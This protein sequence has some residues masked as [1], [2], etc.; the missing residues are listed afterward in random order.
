MYSS[1]CI[2]TLAASG[3]QDTPADFQTAVS[4][5]TTPLQEWMPSVTY[6]PVDNEFLLL[7][8]ATGVRDPGGENMYSLHG[9]RISPDG[10]LLGEAFMPLPTIDTARRILPRAAHNAFTNQ[11]MVV[12]CM[13][14]PVTGWD[15]F[16]TIVNSTGA[17]LAGPLC[18]SAQPT[19]ANHAFI[20]FN[21]ARRQYLIAYNDSRSGNQ[22]VFGVIVDEKGAVVKADFPIC[23]APGEQQNP[24]VC[25]NPAN[26]TFLINWEDFRN[27]ATWTEPGDMYGALLDG[28]GT[29]IKADIDR[30]SVV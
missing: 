4:I 7:W 1:S 22:D 18:L 9:R 2:S 15:P 26:D 6:N 21:P 30:K 19:N 20:V 25:Y 24:F 12:F 8:H 17:V 5:S 27:V 13:E 11:Y 16:I 29:I 23:T 3:G 10:E 14:Q 28:D